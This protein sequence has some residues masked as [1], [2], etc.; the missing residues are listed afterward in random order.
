MGKRNSLSESSFEE[1][2]LMSYDS[3]PLKRQRFES[4]TSA[5]LT[6]LALRKTATLPNSLTDDSSFH[7]ELVHSGDSN[8]S[9]REARVSAPS[10]T[11]DEE[12]DSSQCTEATHTASVARM[13]T[14]RL[15][16]MALRPPQFVIMS[17]PTTV[18]KPWSNLPP[19]RPLPCP[20]RLPSAAVFKNT[21]KS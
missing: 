8:V 6:L 13:E 11:D 9:A 2:N 19:G 18:R 12:E 17:K 7:P 16:K 5:A 15:S 21:T 3:L 1:L 10:I 14:Q 20:P 4:N